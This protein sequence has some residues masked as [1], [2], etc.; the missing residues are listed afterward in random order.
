MRAL[1]WWLLA[2]CCGLGCPRVVG[3]APLVDE[4]PEGDAGIPDA[5]TPPVIESIEVIPNRSG[6]DGGVL[7]RAF[8]GDLLRVTGRNWNRELAQL[9]VGS[10]LLALRPGSSDTQ[11]EAD[12]PNEMTSGVVRV[13]SDGRSG[14]SFD[15]VRFLGPGHLQALRSHGAIE[16][17]LAITAAGTGLPNFCAQTDV[18]SLDGKEEPVGIG[19]VG[20]CFGGQAADSLVVG[21][22]LGLAPDP[23]AMKYLATVSLQQRTTTEM[24]QEMRDAGVA[25]AHVEYLQPVEFYTQGG[26]AV[27]GEGRYVLPVGV[28]QVVRQD[29]PGDAPRLTRR[30]R[31]GWWT[32][33]EL[34]VRAPLVHPGGYL[35]APFLMVVEMLG[36]QDY[37]LRTVS[38]PDGTVQV[39][40]VAN[41]ET[42][43]VPVAMGMVGPGV[44]PRAGHEYQNVLLVLACEETAPQQWQLT[45]QVYDVGETPD[46]VTPAGKAELMVGNS[47]SC[48][49]QLCSPSWDPTSG[50]PLPPAPPAGILEI[51]PWQTD[52]FA[53]V[54]AA[55]DYSASVT[56]TA[57]Q[58]CVLDTSGKMPDGGVGPGPWPPD[59]GG[60][61]DL[62]D[63]G[64]RSLDDGGSVPTDGDAGI[65]DGGEGD[66]S[67]P[68][69][70]DLG[71]VVRNA[72][73]L[74]SAGRVLGLPPTDPTDPSGARRLVSYDNLQAAA[75]GQG[76]QT[77]STSVAYRAVRSYDGLTAVAIPTSGG[78]VDKLTAEG[79]LLDR[80]SIL[81][82][83]RGAW[84]LRQAGKIAVAHE[85]SIMITDVSGYPS[86]FQVSYGLP[87]YTVASMADDEGHVRWLLTT[88]LYESTWVMLRWDLE[89]PALAVD[90]E[91]VEPA[92]KP[93]ILPLATTETSILALRIRNS[94]E[95]ES[96]CPT[97]GVPPGGGAEKPAQDAWM[98]VLPR[99]GDPNNKPEVVVP[100]TC[101]W[102]YPYLS[103]QADRLY[104]Y[105]TD[106]F[107]RPKLVTVDFSVAPFVVDTR[108]GGGVYPG[109]ALPSGA[110]L[111]IFVHEPLYA[112]ELGCLGRDGQYVSMG[113]PPFLDGSIVAS[114]DGRRLYVGT[115]G[116][117]LEMAMAPRD[118]GPAGCPDVEVLSRTP[119][120]ATPD[121]M[122]VD[123]TGRRLVW[124]DSE[125]QTFGMVE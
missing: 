11:L 117:L 66:A 30:I 93:F 27:V 17:Q 53:L 51:V 102:G 5:G 15:E 101:G 33:D 71:P 21:F 22:N 119:I 13:V 16:P 73:V 98:V 1:R 120:S 45:A 29:S 111:G 107:G 6:V 67:R 18:P 31:A 89:S 124:S 35:A 121:Q 74:P 113:P 50:Q 100:E 69:R 37:R 2:A 87:F 125:G 54:P 7:W 32:S 63:G 47:M 83:P 106:I 82:Q 58:L 91:M 110:L 43:A 40:P 20:T 39:E 94:V 115:Q 85:R 108:L 48:E 65:P 96:P 88:E 12:I 75:Y 61:P 4:K 46:T 104:L 112:P 72:A 44:L 8:A 19:V 55:V 52:A 26:D 59:N 41:T 99:G 57:V 62:S 36:V 64:V 56:S 90:V 105:T 25:G 116:V 34:E 60:V 80:V 38:F 42:H 95:V 77:V 49:Y 68:A 84:P 92:G 14:V 70:V 123:P 79:T 118:N 78:Q 103:A 24:F 10:T 23:T 9:Y 3:P 76:G 28:E 86:P 109:V 97:Q 122:T 81:G 114:P